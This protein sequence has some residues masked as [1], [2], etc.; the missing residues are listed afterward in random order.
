MHVEIENEHKKEFIRFKNQ[1]L[2]FRGNEKIRRNKLYPLS[3]E[4]KEYISELYNKGYGL[5]VL[6]RQLEISYTQIRRVFNS[7]GIEIRHGQNIV[8][9]N[10]RKFRSEKAKDNNPF[11]DW[12]NS[13]PQ[14]LKDH[15]YFGIQGYYQKKD[16]SFVWLRSTWEYIY[17]KWLDSINMIW[18]IE[19]TQFRLDNGESYRPDFFVQTKRGE[20]IIEIKGWKKNRT[21]KFEMLKKEHPHLNLVLIDDIKQ[22]TTNYIKDLKEWKKVRLLN[23]ELKQLVS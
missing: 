4:T 9:E 13:R 2:L 19:K 22:Y 17:A 15:N 12:T 23:Q 8:T 14:L 10:L 18:Y 11:M 1:V 5:K 6:A 7:L 16:G 21:Y 20:Y 3:N